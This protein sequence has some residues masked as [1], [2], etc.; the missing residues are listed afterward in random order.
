MKRK[1]LLLFVVLCFGGC[2]PP[3]KPIVYW[4]KDGNGWLV[5]V[6][7]TNDS[8]NHRYAELKKEFE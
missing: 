7:P 2:T 3:T 6:V 8:E 1:L 5:P 4:D